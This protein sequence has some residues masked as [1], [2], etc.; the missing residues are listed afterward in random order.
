PASACQAEGAVV[1]GAGRLTVDPCGLISRLTK[2]RESDQRSASIGLSSVGETSML[3]L[4]SLAVACCLLAAVSCRTAETPLSD[5]DLDTISIYIKAT[6]ENLR[7]AMPHGIPELMIP[8]L[9]PLSLP[10]IDIPRIKEGVADVKLNMRNFVM[11]GLS[12]FVVRD[13]K[14]HTGSMSIELDLFFPQVAARADYNLDGKILIFP[15]YGSGPAAIQI[16][17]LSIRFVASVSIEDFTRVQL[18]NL[19]VDLTFSQVQMYL[20]GIVGGGNLGSVV[21]TLL[22]AM[23][24]LIYDRLK[25]NLLPEVNRILRTV[26]N[27]ELAKVDL[28]D[29]LGGMLPYSSNR[30]RP[31]DESANN[32]VDRLM[33]NLRPLI[34]ANNLDPISIP[35]QRVSFSKK[36]LLVTVWGSARMYNGLAYGL[37][38][39]HRAGNC[40]IGAQGTNVV[41]GCVIGIDNIRGSFDSRA[42]FMGIGVNAGISFLVS[43]I[44]VVFR[45]SADVAAGSS[46]RLDHFAISEVSPVAVSISGL[47]P[48]DWIL[49]PV[50]NVVVNAVQHQIVAAIESPIR[51]ELSKVLGSVSIPGFP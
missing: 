40:N 8:P 29:I 38:T 18:N 17:D 3:K 32:Y 23:G 39:I 15:L 2:R 12:S 50:A 51:H 46:P 19:Q 4:L 44:R 16:N 36:I 42:E 27:N 37:S 13:A 25:G 30:L 1:R 28:R 22:N 43:R 11:N 6:L 49:T 35:E 5:P 21:N 45:V 47:G 41:V 34:H 14:G 48:L 24:K 9:E 7:Q 20:E 10:V 31:V 33:A 26:I